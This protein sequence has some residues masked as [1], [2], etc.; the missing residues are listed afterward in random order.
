MGLHQTK[1]FLHSKG[2]HQ[3]MKRQPTELENIFNDT[4]EKWLK[5][6]IYKIHIKTQ[7]QKNKQH[8]LK[9]GNGAE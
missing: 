7:Y 1:K 6:K 5:S 2:N 8:N 3:Q 9:K 4:S